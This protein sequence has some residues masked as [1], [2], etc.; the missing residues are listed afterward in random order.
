MAYVGLAFSIA[1]VFGPPIGAYFAT[2]R[3]PALPFL[4]VASQNVYAT[5]AA[6]TM[7]LLIVE[8]LLLARYLPETKGLVSFAESKPSASTSAEQARRLR[9]LERLHFAFLFIFR[10]ATL[11]TSGII[12]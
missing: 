11:V 6:L 7:V 4:P 1:F 9:Q 8:T 12:F 5:P 2:K 10:C 3:M